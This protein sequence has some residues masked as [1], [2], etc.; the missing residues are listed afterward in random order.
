MDHHKQ[1]PL[2]SNSSNSIQPKHRTTVVI[3]KW[4]QSKEILSQIEKARVTFSNRKSLFTSKDISFQVKLELVGCYVF[5]V[6][7]YGLKV[8]TTTETAGGF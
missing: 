8:W 5:S 7:F 6:L 4:D 3:S 1:K 2:T